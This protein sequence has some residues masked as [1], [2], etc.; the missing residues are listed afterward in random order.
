MLK[1]Q[2]LNKKLCIRL[3]GGTILIAVALIIFKFTPI[4]TWI[5][6][7]NLRLLKEQAGVFA[8]VGFIVVYAI[9]TILSVPG[10][11]LT[12]SGG[13]LFGIVFGTIWTVIGASL[14]AIGAFLIARFIAGDWARQQFEKGARLRQLQQGIEQNGFWFVL[15]IR[16]S[17]IFPFI[18]V[19]YLLGLTPIG[20]PAYTLATLI[21]IVPGTFAYTWLGYGGL[22]VASGGAPLPLLG[23]LGVLGLL[24]LLPIVW[25]WLK[26]RSTGN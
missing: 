3:L 20:L 14:G 18:A 7:E 17:P 19:N 9:A 11:I 10:T 15:S 8:P 2:D 1:K 24:S 22:E 21:G 6:L 4:A 23:G 26:N 25:K 5:K 16:L 12:L 13:A